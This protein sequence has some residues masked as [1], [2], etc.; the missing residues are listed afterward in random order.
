[1]LDE[2]TAH[3]GQQ[4]SVVVVRNLDLA[5]RTPLFDTLNSAIWR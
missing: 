2:H 3:T 1:M 5:G 4:L